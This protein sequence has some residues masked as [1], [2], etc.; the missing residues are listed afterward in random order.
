MK[1]DIDKNQLEEYYIINNRTIPECAVIFGVSKSRIKTALREFGIRK[2]RDKITERRQ[3]TCRLR[4]GGNSPASSVEIVRRMQRTKMLRYGDP[5][6]NNIEKIKQTNLS[7][8]GVENISQTISG[9]QRA[10][11]QRRARDTCLAKYGTERYWESPALK[12]S[13]QKGKAAHNR[14]CLEKYGAECYTQSQNFKDRINE[15]TRKTKETNMK[16]YGVSNVSQ[17]PGVASKK[18]THYHYR[19][20]DDEI[21]FDSSWELALWIYAKDHHED[22]MKNPCSFTYYYNGVQHVYFPDFKYRG[23]IIEIKGAQFWD[24]DKMICPL[25]HELDGLFEA[26]HQCMIENKVRIWGAK[27]IA[28]ALEYVKAEYG[29][30]YLRQFKK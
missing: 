19:N 2:S 14:T 22:I 26:K 16:R 23:S 1:K 28:F 5:G 8:Y 29:G 4:Y 27:E 6:Y 17:I 12:S 30:Q 15:R 21:D 3:E 10:D 9:D 24:G 18:G 13:Y 25:N 20:G 11:M 7:K